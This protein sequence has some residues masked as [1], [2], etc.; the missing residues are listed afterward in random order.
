MYF[1]REDMHSGTNCT[2]FRFCTFVL[3]RNTYFETVMKWSC[4]IEFATCRTYSAVRT[5]RRLDK[6]KRTQNI[7]IGSTWLLLFPDACTASMLWLRC[8]GRR[9]NDSFRSIHLLVWII[10]DNSDGW[11]IDSGPFLCLNDSF[12]LLNQNWTFAQQGARSWI[13]R[14]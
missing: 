12:R 1:I 5:K 2:L 11:M 10:Q 8:A 7:T 14:M 6:S 3:R 13:Y 4:I 9:L